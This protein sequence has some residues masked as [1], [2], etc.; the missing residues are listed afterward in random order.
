[1]KKNPTL[2]STCF[3]SYFGTPSKP[4]R[5]SSI[6]RDNSPVKP[7]L[8]QARTALKMREPDEFRMKLPLK[9]DPTTVE[10]WQLLRLKA[11]VL[12][13]DIRRAREEMVQTQKGSRTQIA[14]LVQAER[15]QQRAKRALSSLIYP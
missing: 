10:S 13:G 15:A 14:V 12:E 5:N 11:Q 4:R 6:W 7:P 9:P 2:Q 1:M 8:L 3:R